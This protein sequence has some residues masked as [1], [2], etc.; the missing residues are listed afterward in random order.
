M[1]GVSGLDISRYSKT[2]IYQSHHRLRVLKAG[3]KPPKPESHEPNR[4]SGWLDLQR[5]KVSVQP[6]AEW[7]QM[8]DEAWRLQREHFWAE[9]MAGVVWETI[10]K[11]KEPP[12][13]GGDGRAERSPPFFGL[14][15]EHVASQHY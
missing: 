9:D 14:Q 13:V 4:E 2:V 15:N 1:D 11:K 3:E 12:L 10:P 8:F 6:A 7:K 5:V